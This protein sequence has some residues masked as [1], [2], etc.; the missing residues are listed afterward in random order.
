MTYDPTEAAR[1]AAIADQ[2][3]HGPKTREELAAEYKCDVYDTAELGAIFDV[4]GFLAPFVVVR[5]KSDGKRG[6]LEFQHMPRFYWGWKE[7]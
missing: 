7:D 5:R 2:K 6:S 3:A 1:R 4:T